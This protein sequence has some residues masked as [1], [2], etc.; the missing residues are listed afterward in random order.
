MIVEYI[1]YRVPAERGEEFEAAYA[2]AA[3]PL[4]RAPQCV[5][6]ELSRCVEDPEW[7]V[8][9]I[10]W[11]SAQDHLAGFRGSENFR[12]FF[13]EIKPY[14]EQIEEMRHYERTAVAGLGGSVPTLFEWAGGAE[15]FERLT[16]AF[17]RRVLEDD[18]VGPLFAGMD[19]DHP[20]Y[21]AMWLGEVFGGPGRYTE[22]RGGYHHMLGQH[23]GKAI[24]EPQRRRWMNLLLDAAD[25]T[26]LPDDPEFRAAFVGYIEWGTRLAL[27]N[28]QPDARPV[29]QAPVPRWGW[30]VAPPYVAGA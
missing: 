5:E 8:L 24:S 2:R 14:V 7:Y 30:G 19:H 9:R 18:V 22:Q 26:G 6:Y 25:E 16:E 15:T 17:Y 3:V 23:L 20:K 1:R 11:T 12:A 29:Q 10:A 4:A 21:V 13:A 28:S 27:A